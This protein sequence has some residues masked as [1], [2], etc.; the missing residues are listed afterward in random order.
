MLATFVN[1]LERED[2]QARQQL[3]QAQVLNQLAITSYIASYV[4]DYYTALLFTNLNDILQ[5]RA[6]MNQVLTQHGLTYANHQLQV[7]TI[8][9]PRIINIE[10]MSIDDLTTN[11]ALANA[12]ILTAS[13]GQNYGD[14]PTTWPA[15]GRFTSGFGFRA[16]PITG[17][18]SF[19][20][21]VDLAAPIGTPIY[22][23]FNG[24]VVESPQDTGWGNQVFI[25]QG[26][27]RIRYAHMDNIE[28]VVGQQVSQG[29]RIGTVGNTGRTTGPHLHLGLYLQNVAVNPEYIFSRR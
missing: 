13:Q 16:D 6:T 27:L 10:H 23:W 18:L 3:A 25:R 22:A 5:A 9:G 11:L 29:Q 8:M 19:H 26:D 21:G 17:Q 28:V 14:V 2:F 4:E 1:E 24:T 15:L 7:A 20:T 12:Q